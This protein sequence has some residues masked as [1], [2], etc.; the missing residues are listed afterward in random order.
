MI[1]EVGR[2]ALILAFMIS[3]SQ[4]ILPLIG[5]YRNDRRLMSFADA[6]A[7]AQFFF[8]AVAFAC[9]VYCFVTSDYSV[10]VVAANSNARM[11]LLYRVTG[12]WGNHEGSMLLWSFILALFGA[13]IGTFGKAIPN[14][15]R[16]RVLSV[17]GIIGLGFLAFI[18]FTSNPFARLF[19][20]PIEGNGLNPLLEDP[21]LAFHPPFLYLGYVGFSTA[22]SFAAAALIEGGAGAAWARYARPWILAA[23]ILLTVGICGG[24]IWAYYELGWGGWWGWDPVEN[25]SLMPWLLGTA[26]L[27]CALVVERRQ[28]FIRWTL[29]LGVM[30]FTMSLVGTFVVRSGVLSSVH[31][32]ALDP[33]RGVFILGLIVVATGG[34]L[35]LYAIRSSKLPIGEPF[36]LVSRETS[37]LLNNVLIVS[38][39][40]TVFVG[41]FYPLFIDLIGRD[42]ISVGPP[43]YALTFVPIA[44]PILVVMV[45][46]PF[47]KWRQDRLASALRETRPALIAAVLTAVAIL[48]LSLGTQIPAALGLGLAA[49][50]AV[51]SLQILFRRIRLGRVAFSESVRLAFAL[52]RSTYGVVA[53]HLGIGLLVAGITGSV[54]WKEELVLAMKPGQVTQFAGYKIE[55]LKAEVG[56]TDDYEFQRGFFSAAMGEDRSPILLIPELR[57]YPG[58][59]SET[60]EASIRSGPIANLY[61]NMGEQNGETWPVHLFYHPLV[62]WIWIGAFFMAL[63]GAL[64]W[65]NGRL[66]SLARAPASAKIAAAE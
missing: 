32:F 38:A 41:T 5:A 35:A 52:P 60:T 13:T 31:A 22:F 56:Q 14:R 48:A 61:M 49:W 2:F 42:K 62:V 34:S 6:A 11:P 9:L 37:L 36:G 64:S 7:Q 54:F 33:A 15:L 55:M 30:T 28:A 66:R 44:I 26:L 29:L 50:I 25:A 58:R 45:V 23:W 51:G 47:L 24:S 21:G 40:A 20:A 4:A 59:Q 65:S 1:A 17:Q 57:F 3:V 12:T 53:A 10:E 19:P 18:L 46:G 63:G 16:A 43:F 27:H 39:M 8:V